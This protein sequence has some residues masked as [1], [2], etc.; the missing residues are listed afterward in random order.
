MADALKTRLERRLSLPSGDKAAL[1]EDLLENA[2]LYI[3]GYTGR[4]R[5]P[6]ALLGAQTELAAAA[7]DRLGMEGESAHGEGGVSVTVESLPASQRLLLNRYRVAKVGFGC[8]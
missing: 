8:E 7:Y 2:G 6:D 4:D 1:L 5:V 3:M